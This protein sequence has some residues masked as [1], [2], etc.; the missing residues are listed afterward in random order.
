M[1][2][3]MASLLEA[4]NVT[5]IFGTKEK[6][7]VALNDVTFSIDAD[8]PSFTAVVGESG[9]GKT[10][11]ARILMG[12]LTPTQGAVRYRGGELHTAAKREQMQFRRDAVSYT[13]L[14]LPTT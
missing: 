13:H 10:T 5:Q 14:T 6:R 3:L 8:S 4:R 9:S 1:G 2:V 11:L 7:N 12:F